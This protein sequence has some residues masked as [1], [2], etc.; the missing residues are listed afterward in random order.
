[1]KS[2][3]V[4]LCEFWKLTRLV[5]G[6]S[7][8]ISLR[9]GGNEGNIRDGSRIAFGDRVRGGRAVVLCLICL[10]QASFSR[11]RIIF[12]LRRWR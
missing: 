11:E 12:S 8:C 9:L 7:I 1:M 2:V 10:C 3:L 6:R 5:R 4:H